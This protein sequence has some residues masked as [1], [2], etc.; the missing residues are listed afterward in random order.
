MFRC[1]VLRSLVFVVN[2][3]LNSMF[4]NFL[5]CFFTGVQGV[6]QNHCMFHLPEVKCAFRPQSG[7]ILLLNTAKVMHGSLRCHED[8]S[9]GLWGTALFCPSNIF[10]MM[11]TITK[12]NLEMVGGLSDVL[13]SLPAPKRAPVKAT[14]VKTL[15]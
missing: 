2:I 7:T 6:Q 10:K 3:L 14:L 13:C 5:L 4:N 8:T 9:L 1:F 11:E 12:K 15:I